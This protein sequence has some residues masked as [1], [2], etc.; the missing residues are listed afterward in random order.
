MR[1]KRFIITIAALAIIMC[2]G[3]AE[4]VRIGK[5][6]QTIG[7]AG[8]PPAPEKPATETAIINK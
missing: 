3:C 8:L 7:E 6:I 4:I 5:A 1:N 2:T